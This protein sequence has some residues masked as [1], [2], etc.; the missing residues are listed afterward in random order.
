[1]TNPPSAANFA[2]LFMIGEK[3]AIAPRAQVIAVAEAARQQHAFDAAERF[4]LVPQDSRV[5]AHH[6]RER[7]QRVAVVQ[8][9]GESH[10]APLHSPST[11]KR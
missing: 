9:A 2:T 4:V 3:R 8:R 7:V 11:S 6:V 10:D 1:M 5:L